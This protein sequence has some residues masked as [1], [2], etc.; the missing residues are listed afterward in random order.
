MGHIFTII[1]KSATGKDFLFNRILDELKLPL[2][3]VVTYTTRPIRAGEI[4]GIVYNFR[5][6]PEFF[7]LKEKGLV[8]ESRC[9]HTMLGDWYY[10]TVDDGQ[11]TFENDY[12][13]ITTLEGFES[14]RNYYGSKRV[15][16]LYVEVNDGERL[17]RAV[18]R[19]MGQKAPKFDEVCRRYLADEIDFSDDKIIRLGITRR[20]NNLDSDTCLQELQK[21]IKSRLL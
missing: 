21:E 5:T 1:G 11:I 16:P 19:E 9:Y 15:V 3:T 8:I 2:K 12:L 13:M 20:F 18:K 17:S 14:L 10:F 7:D 4:D 6:I